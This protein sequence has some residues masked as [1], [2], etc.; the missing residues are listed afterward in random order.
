MAETT[1]TFPP[2]TAEN[3]VR[4]KP[5]PNNPVPNKP[6]YEIRNGDHRPT[7]WEAMTRAGFRQ[8][9]RVARARTTISYSELCEAVSEHAHV[10]LQP[11]S[12]ALLLLLERI[13][14]HSFD[15]TGVVLTALVRRKDT[16]Y[17]PGGGF[18]SVCRSLGLIDHS[19]NERRQEAFLIDHQRRI[20][21]AY[22]RQSTRLRRVAA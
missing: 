1:I 8:L 20:E 10:S 6:V 19:L 16:G 22:G 14:R 5:V 4:D 11:D 9:E 18:Y 21:A 13:A 2:E 12:M 7:E 15:R 3:P 17:D